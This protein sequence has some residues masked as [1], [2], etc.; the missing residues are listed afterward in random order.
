MSTFR[1]KKLK[2]RN[3]KIILVI[4]LAMIMLGLLGMGK[5]ISGQTGHAVPLGPNQPGQQQLYQPPT[6]SPA[7]LPQGGPAPGS[8]STIA[9]VPQARTH[10]ETAKELGGLLGIIITLAAKLLILVS[11]LIDFSLAIGKEV[12]QLPIVQEGFKTTLNFANLGFVLAIIIIAFATIFRLESYAMKK[13]LWKLIVAALLVNFSLVIAGAFINISNIMTDF[14]Q[15]KDSESLSMA[16]GGILNPQQL[17]QVKGKD[18][19][20]EKLKAIMEDPFAFAFKYIAGLF[21]VIIFTIIIILTFLALAL[22]LLIR[23][24]YLSILLIIMPLAWLAW[25]FPGTQ[26]HWQKW[27]QQFIRWIIFAPAMLFFIFIVVQTGTAMREAQIGKIA[28]RPN[29][30]EPGKAFSDDL[31]LPDIKDEQGKEIG[32]FAFVGQLVITTGLLMGG[33]FVANSLGIAGAKTFY[34]AAQGAGKWFGGAVKGAGRRAGLGAASRVTGGERMKNLTEKLTASKVP[35]AKLVARGLN[36][37]GVKTE[38][39]TQKSYEDEAKLYSGPRLETAIRTSR[40]ARRATFLNKAAKERD[41]SDKIKEEFFADGETMEKIENELK[42]SGYKP[43]DIAKTIGYN[44]KMLKAETKEAL[45]KAAKELYGTFNQENWNKISPSALLD[46]KFG[47]I[48]TENLLN[49][50]AGSLSKIL[51]KVKKSEDLKKIT[52]KVKEKMEE[53]I[54]KAAT[55]EEIDFAAKLEKSVKKS[56]AKRYFEVEEEKAEEKES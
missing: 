8:V 5:T 43:G 30:M 47:E 21:F 32:F 14:F 3:K 4:L 38:Q 50:S 20:L 31:F 29:I 55:E 56:L 25:I 9:P 49:R 28:E 44:S 6:G 53:T 35:G 19:W 54:K 1:L 23:A 10:Q 39:A 17:A 52:K 48:I 11:A 51:P 45:D 2:R 12:I 36:R 15:L 13:T 26:A 42:R 34:G 33:L 27:W 37:L 46:E 41:I 22:M 40:G 7:P 18:S 24:I 16:L